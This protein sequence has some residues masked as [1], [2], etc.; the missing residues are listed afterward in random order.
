MTSSSA[1][2]I[3]G[4]GAKAGRPAEAPSTFAATTM[5]NGTTMHEKG[6]AAQ[7]IKG[8]TLLGEE[9]DIEN[10]GTKGRYPSKAQ[11]IDQAMLGVG[12]GWY[13]WRLLIVTAMAWFL[14]YVG[15]HASDTHHASWYHRHSDTECPTSCMLIPTVLDEVLHDH[16]AG[17]FK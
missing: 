11:L 13:H 6:G 1:D 16:C 14:D 9:V 10:S 3:A 8:K 15:T 2:S 17:S 12:M 4:E 5:F 7:N